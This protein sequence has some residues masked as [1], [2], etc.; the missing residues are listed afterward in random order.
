MWT[1]N[2]L[3]HYYKIQFSIIEASMSIEDIIILACITKKEEQLKFVK[4]QGQI[5]DIFTKCIK[6]EDF[7]RLRMHIGVTNQV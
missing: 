7:R 4:F 6:F 1:T 5:V 2:Q 3:L